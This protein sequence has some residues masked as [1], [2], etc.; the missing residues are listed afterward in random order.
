MGRKNNFEY[1][2]IG[3]GPAGT[4]AALTLAQAKKRICIIE[5]NTLGGSHLNTRDIPYLVSLHASHSLSHI[6]D[7]PEFR[8]NISFSLPSLRSHCDSIINDISLDLKRAYKNAGISFLRG[9]ANFLDSNTVAVSDKKLTADHF[10]LATGSKP[11]IT[12]IVGSDSPI[13][14]T[15]ESALNIR[16]IPKVAVIVGGGSAGCEIA[17]FYAELGSKVIIIEAT[18]RLL[19]REDQEVSTYMSTFFTNHLGI[20]V[21]TDSKVV[22]IRKDIASKCVIFKTDGKEKMVRTESIILATGSQPVLDYGLENAGIKYKPSGIITNKYFQTSA[23]HIY[24]IGDCTGEEPSTERASYEGHLL[25]TN[26][27][28]R[29]K[30]LPN[31]SGFARITKTHPEIA[32]VGSSENELIKNKRKYQKSIVYLSQI[33]A[34]KITGDGFVKLLSD[35]TGHIL[36]ATIISPNAELMISELSLAIRHR[37]PALEIASTPHSVDNYNYAV[38]LAAKQ[39]LSAK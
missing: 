18:K 12:N 36:G 14:Q 3:S 35:K 31:Y 11:K 38:K 9:A 4:T 8:N 24:A 19:P 29:S 37:I 23:K 13:Y 5:E 20:T 28:G 1:I 34:G 27:L 26:L 22:E 6:S 33:A 25:A 21:L 7:L 30:S 32:T 15:P 16:R 17:E 10:I 2:I 39:L